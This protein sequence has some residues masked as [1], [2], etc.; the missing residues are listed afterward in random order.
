MMQPYKGKTVAKTERFYMWPEDPSDVRSDKELSLYAK[1]DEKFYYRNFAGDITQL[2]GDGGGGGGIQ[3]D[4]Y[5]QAGDWLYVAGTDGS[6]GS[7][8]S[9]NG[10]EI[11][12]YA[13]GANSGMKLGSGWDIELESDHRI[14]LNASNAVEISG[15]HITLNASNV[16][17]LYLDEDNKLDWTPTV[18]TFSG[19]MLN[20]TAANLHIQANGVRLET[21]DSFDIR[22]ISNSDMEIS[23]K[24]LMSIGSGGPDGSILMAAISDASG[25]GAAIQYNC[26]GRGGVLGTYPVSGHFFVLNGGGLYG[27]SD[28]EDSYF[29]VRDYSTTDALMRIVR[30][31]G[32][33]F[34]FHIKTGATWVADL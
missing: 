16:I 30:T 12:L 33:T 14:K 2:G 7:E 10:F 3:F 31:A 26:L 5:P 24:T 34:S 25:T 1:T 6:G 29:E 11:E 18:G 13:S 28:S 23:S 27:G 20:T 22:M 21:V 19:F 32:G 8:E 15:P 4:T 9:P 17:S